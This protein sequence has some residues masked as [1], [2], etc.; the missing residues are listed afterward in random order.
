MTSIIR[1]K[2]TSHLLQTVDTLQHLYSGSYGNYESG[3]KEDNIYLRQSLNDG[4]GGNIYKDVSIYIS[5]G[6]SKDTMYEVLSNAVYIYY[7]YHICIY[8]AALNFVKFTTQILSLDSELASEISFLRK[9]LLM[10]VCTVPYH[11]ALL[12]HCDI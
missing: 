6:M 7:I 4:T 11:A 8:Q 5:D 2:F 3:H 9:S 1:V 12:V 10:E